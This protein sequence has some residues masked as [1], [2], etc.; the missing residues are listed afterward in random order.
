MTLRQMMAVSAAA[1]AAF[2]L[3]ACSPK[4]EEHAAEAP[5]DSTMAAAT[6]AESAATMDAAATDAAAAAGANAAAAAP[7][8]SAMAPASESAM[9]PATTTPTP[10]QPAPAAEHAPAGH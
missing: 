4:A 10:Q 7:A 2:A 8:E 6:E 3:G 1:T 9:A 5:A